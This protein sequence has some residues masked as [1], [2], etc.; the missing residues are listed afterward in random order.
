MKKMLFKVILS[1]TFICLM[2]PI[3]LAIHEFAP[4]IERKIMCCM[5][6]I[7]K[8]EIEYEENRTSDIMEST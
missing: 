4:N 8:E 1:D 2:F 6:R 5:D 7:F 3:T